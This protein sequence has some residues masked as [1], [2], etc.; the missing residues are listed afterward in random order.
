MKSTIY[1]SYAWGISDESEETIAVMGLCKALSDYGFNLVLDK[2]HLD[3]HQSLPDFFKVIGYGGIVIPIVGKRYLQRLNCL[4]EAAHMIN[5]GDIQERIFPLVLSDNHEIYDTL[6]RPAIINELEQ[7]WS[8]KEKELSEA[9]DF[10]HSLG[11]GRLPFRHDVNLLHQ[12]ISTISEFVSHI[13]TSKQFSLEHELKNNFTPFIE[14]ILARTR[15]KVAKPYYQKFEGEYFGREEDI[16]FVDDFIMD[17]SHHFLLLYGV[18]GMGKSHLLSIC[19]EKNAIGR[20]FYWVKADRNFELKDLFKACNLR[21]PVELVSNKEICN[22]FLEEF[23]SEEIFLIIDDFYEI[24]DVDVRELL[25]DLAC[26][27]AGKLLLI[28]RAVPKEIEKQKVY[29]LQLPALKREPFKQAMYAYISTENKRTFSDAELDKIF[30]KAQG[31]PLGG[32]LII[33]LADFGDKL[34][35]ILNDLP[36]FEAELDEEGKR[37]SERLLDNIFNKAGIGE[38]NLLCEFSALFGF[39]AF[40][41]IRKLPSFKIEIFNSLVNRRKF[42]NNDGEGKYSSHAMIKDYAYEKLNNKEEVHRKIGN[43]FEEKL[44]ESKKLDWD[45]ADSIILHYKKVGKRD[46]EFFGQRMFLKFRDRDVKSIIEQSLQ[47]TIRNYSS[48]LEI[49]PNYLPYYNELGMTY[50]YNHQDQ[51][52]ILTFQKGLEKSPGDVVL[53]NELGIT[54]RESG[55]YQ[56]AIDTFLQAI[57]Y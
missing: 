16:K 45:L 42:I 2:T 29:H 4:I 26:L 32:H 27:P 13:G 41:V 23:T 38:I 20:T 35:D 44:K 28:S 8:D 6:R 56:L 3:Y 19:L 54:Y 39:S 1:I 37:F 36:K 34:D 9:I 49:Y 30:D 48:L 33:R 31:Y 57:Q 7:Y 50:R 53:L 17:D 52:A 40:D 25:P 51:K 21:F 43:Y 11:H 12:V 46:L 15:K 47:N 24:I 55:K 14:F 5:R 10:S 22:R 18:G